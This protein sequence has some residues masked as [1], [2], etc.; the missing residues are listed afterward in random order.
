M[1]VSI[2]AIGSELLGLSRLDTNSL[3]ITEVL[4][5]RSI[6]VSR[7]VIV[8]DDLEDIVGELKTAL[9]EC[10][11][12]I[13]TG[14][15]GPTEDD[16]TKEAI[17]RACDLTLVEDASVLG[18]IRARF[19]ERGIPMP[20]VNRKQ[21]L[22][23]KGQRTIYNERGTAPGFHIHLAHHRDPRHLWVF[24]GVPYELEGMIESDLK[25]WLDEKFSNRGGVYRRSVK[26]AGMTESAV[27]E[28]LSE[29]YASHPDEEIG[30]F[31]T[32]NEIQ[33]QL[34]AEGTSD[35]AFSHLTGLERELREI[36][37]ERVYGIDD[38]AIEAVVGRMLVRRSATLATAESCSG[39]L[40]GSR[41][42]DIP[43]SSQYY[44]GGLVTYS[45]EAKIDCAG[46]DA[47]LLD[48]HGEVSEEVAVALARGVRER[49][50]TTFGVGITGIAGPSGGTKKK[51][52]GTVHIAV[53]TEELTEHRR[54]KLPGPRDRIKRLSTQAALDLLRLTMLRKL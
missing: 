23:F 26:I 41:L 24:P 49:F 8:G 50:G 12:V 16:L 32:N 11:T 36:F 33:V 22:V 6:R 37:G 31:A 13:T 48:A 15:L 42:T 46:V 39:G 3:R 20:E 34:R 29:F 18:S 47:S 19:E 25:S 17:A 2:I 43:G 28:K 35:E 14:G 54:L 38:D 5:Q 30:V 27:E 7:K 44:M 21:A 45:R 9:A 40:L 53:V 51:P 4:E 10:D 52:V 1:K